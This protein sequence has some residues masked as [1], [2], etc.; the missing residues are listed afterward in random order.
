MPLSSPTE[1][2]EPP[3]KPPFDAAKWAMVLLGVMI[4]T[5]SLLVLAITFRCLINLD[6]ACWDRP[7]PTLFRDWLIE[8]IPVLVA[9]I[10]SGRSRGPP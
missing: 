4:C 10:M 3:P 9:I 1:P 8:I 6:P 7:W 5:P 2:P